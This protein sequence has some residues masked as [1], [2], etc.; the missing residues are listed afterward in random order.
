MIDPSFT[1]GEYWLLE[2]AVLDGTV[3]VSPFLLSPDIGLFYNKQGHEMDRLRLENALV[4]LT[5]RGLIQ[6]CHHDLKNDSSRVGFA[7]EIGSAIDGALSGLYFGLSPQGG[8]NWEAFVCPKWDQFVE[9]SFSFDDDGNERHAI[10]AATRKRLQRIFD[11][12]HYTGVVPMPGTVN[13][14]EISPWQATYWKELSQGCRVEFTSPP[15]TT[16]STRDEMQL[17]Y[18]RI[19]HPRWYSWA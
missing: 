2:T 17:S 10:I 15:R 14:T 16:P 4:R 12:L 5:E 19:S 6:L 13:W 3:P 11:G 8:L 18:Y 7:N 1:R 9:H